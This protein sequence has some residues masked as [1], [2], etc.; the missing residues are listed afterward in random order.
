MLTFLIN[1][2]ILIHMYVIR[3]YN[4]MHL[5]LLLIIEIKSIF[6]NR[7]MKKL[8]KAILHESS[9]DFEIFSL[10]VRMQILLQY[11]TTLNSITQ[12]YILIFNA[13]YSV[14]CFF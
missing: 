5:H 12:V 14:C 8:L 1:A 11:N 3:I 4:G 9:V 7:Y 10:E 6:Y 2:T 13:C